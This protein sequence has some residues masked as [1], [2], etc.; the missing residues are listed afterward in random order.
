VQGVF[1]RETCRLEAEARGVAGWVRN[2]SDGRVEV[3]VEGSP[4]AVAGMVTWC[5]QGPPHARVDALEVY[6]EPANGRPGFRVEP[7]I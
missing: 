2:R 6:D 1:F 7:S 3:F 4:P 5:R